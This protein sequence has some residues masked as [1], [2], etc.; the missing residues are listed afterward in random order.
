MKSRKLTKKALGGA[1]PQISDHF[2]EV[3]KKIKVASGTGKEAVRIIE[4]YKLSRHACYLIA[5]N[6]VQSMTMRPTLTP[7]V[8]M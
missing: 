1:Y 4:D 8:N 6:G 3:G 5:Q 2:A 7:A